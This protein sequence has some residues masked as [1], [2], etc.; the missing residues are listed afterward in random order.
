MKANTNDKED[1][2]EVLT[3]AVETLFEGKS[4]LVLIQTDN[5]EQRCFTSG[6]DEQLEDL[7]VNIAE[8]NESIEQ[9]FDNVKVI[10][11]NNKIGSQTK[12]TKDFE[13]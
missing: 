1:L 12:N 4:F 7:L 13:F 2:R 11:R 8:H 5:N 10:L 6:T 3:E 9:I